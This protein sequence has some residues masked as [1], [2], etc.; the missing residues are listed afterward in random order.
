MRFSNTT[1]MAHVRRFA[2]VIFT[3]ILLN[4]PTPAFAQV[5][6]DIKLV[7]QITI[8]GLRGDLLQRYQRN[9][10]E[11]GFR[12]LLDNGV[13]FT[14]AHYQHANTET[15]VGHATLA[16][17]AHPAVHG[18]VGNVWLDSKTGELAYNIEDPDHPL[19]PTRGITI[20]GTQLD[21]AQKKSRTQ[22]RSPLTLLVPT[23]SDV[24]V[25][26]SAGKARVFGISGKDRGAVALAGHVGKAFWFSTDSGDIQTSTYYY[27]AYPRWV[28]DWNSQRKAKALSGQSWE[29]MYEHSRYLLGHQDDRPYEV[30][31]K[32]YGRIF[33][34]PFGE[35]NDPL[36]GTRLLVSPQGDRLL[37]DFAR[38]LIDAER[39]GQQGYTDYLS[40]SFS[41]VDAVNHFFGPSSLE[42]EDV[43]LQL[44]RT[45]AE[46]LE[47]IDNA[48]G[49]ASTL[50]VLSADH[51]MA[52]MPEYMSELGYPAGRMFAQEVLEIANQLGKELFGIDE[53]CTTFFR[54]TL[55]LNKPAIETAGLDLPGT[56]KEL[57]A[58]LSQIPGI[59]L[60]K[61][62]VDL[63][64]REHSGIAG[65]M[66]RNTHPDRSGD[67]YIA[68]SPYWFMFERGAVAVMH[69]SPWRYDTYVP[70]IFMGPGMNPAKVNRLVHP[71]DI[72]ATLAA[73]LGIPAPAGAQGEVLDEVLTTTLQ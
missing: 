32:G 46:L 73:Y 23:F 11:D 18:L 6:G 54:P 30:D 29:L 2:T 49:L 39:L 34:H 62:T 51:G 33:P 25:A 38:A 37:M 10:G 45:L 3:L 16:T 44:D 22:G 28:E 13:V 20:K 15:I 17:G 68:Q 35:A 43:V 63:L 7:L 53:I 41:G 60:A 65:Q 47:H 59:G 72:V 14:N 58:A 12:Y 64:S 40:V 42:N 1:F 5:R 31:L 24:L 55:Y 9:Y 56:A 52:E 69:G 61:S 4:Q 48:V 67:I 8:D 70:I 57:A 19:L 36:F 27:A 50:V 26:S 21:P 66:Q 71:V